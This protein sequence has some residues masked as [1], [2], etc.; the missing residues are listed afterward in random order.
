[1]VTTT[2]PHNPSKNSP[3]ASPLCSSPA[4][5]T[6]R[7]ISK[8]SFFAIAAHIYTRRWRGA[9]ALSGGMGRKSVVALIL[10]CAAGLL[11]PQ[12]SFAASLGEAR[13][14]VTTG[15]SG[16]RGVAISGGR[17]YVVDGFVD[18]IISYPVGANGILGAARDEIT[19]GLNAPVAIAIS[20]R[21]AYVANA[22]L[23]KIISYEMNP[24]GSLGAMREEEATGLSFPLAIAFSGGRAYVADRLK[25]N[26][27]ISYAMGADGR[28]SEEGRDEASLFNPRAIAFLRGRA[29]VASLSGKIVSYAVKAGGVLGAGRD[30]ITAGL[31]K[32]EAIAFSGGRAYVTDRDLDK[33]ISYAV[34][35]DGSLSEARD[36][37]TTDLSDPRAI[38][39]SGNRVYVADRDIDKII[40]YSLPLPVSFAVAPD[41]PRA[42]AQSDSKIEITWNA[43]L[44]ATHYNVYRSETSDGLFALVRGTISVPHY[45]D[46]DL[47]RNTSYYYQLEACSGNKCS[48]RSP[49]GSVATRSLGFGRDEVT[50][51]LSGPRGVAFSDGR[52]YVAD[53]FIDKIIS[54]PVGEGSG[55]LGAARDEITAGLNAPCRHRD[56]GRSG[57]CG[58]RTSR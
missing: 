50:A 30:E 1:M 23:A 4:A 26:K 48:G 5:T 31:I 57:V 45:R 22:H 7:S 51:G 39:I 20:G 19:A 15:L 58:E 33:L 25:G 41:L 40:S 13:D 2:L 10:A 36:E 11:A 9:K 54:Y 28:L 18:K 16:P 21:R 6:K 35:A 43:V 46:G 32:P 34:G 52:A 27:I 38:A 3:F 53:G 14:E 12:S 29:Y 42:V 8:G 24:N 47:S 17:A 56:F 49:Q 55:K 44:G 37:V